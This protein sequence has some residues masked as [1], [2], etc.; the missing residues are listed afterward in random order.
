LSAMYFIHQNNFVSA[1]ANVAADRRTVR[2]MLFVL[3]VYNKEV[4]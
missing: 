2:A 1:D 3:D 4:V